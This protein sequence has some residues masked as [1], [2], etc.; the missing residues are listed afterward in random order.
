M[1][2]LGRVWMLI[3]ALAGAAV[4]LLATGAASAP[5]LASPHA[6]WVMLAVGFLLTEA[7][8]VHL[9]FRQSRHSFSLADVPLVF[10]LLFA[11]GWQLV[12]GALLGTVLVHG[13]RRLPPVKMAFNLAQLALAL[14]VAIRV[15]HAFGDGAV[16]P[17]DWASAYV[18]ALAASGVTI[19]S[20]IAVISMTEGWI[21][22]AA[23]A[24]MY[25]TDLTVTGTNSTIAIVASIVV[26]KDARALPLLIVLVAIGFL[27]YRGYITERERHERLWFLYEANQTVERS[28][29]VAD[30]VRALLERALA[31]FRC[32]AAELWLLGT[33]RPVF[34]RLRADGEQQL[35]QDADPDTARTL[36]QSVVAGVTTLGEALV[37]PLP[38]DDGPLG[39]LVLSE[40]R[41]VTPQFTPDERELARS[42]AADAA[43]A[44]SFDRLESTV[45]QLRDLEAQLE[46]DRLT[47]VAN[48]TRF[49]AALQETPEA[50]VLAVDVDGF[51]ALNDR[52][53]HAAGDRVLIAVAQR[54]RACVPDDALLARVGADEFGVLASVADAEALAAR[55]VG[56]F[57]LPL[58][59]GGDRHRLGVSVGV[60]TSGLADADVA[61]QQAKAA[62]GGRAEVFA[63]E[64]AV[65]LQRR[66]ALAED[67]RVALR[68]G[69]LHLHYQ[70]IVDL[71]SGDVLGAEAL[72]RWEHPEHGAV[73]PG[74]FVPIAEEAGL[75]GELGR[76]VLARACR[77]LRIWQARH[78]RGPQRI[79]VNLS[80]H[81]LSNPD[82]VGAVRR[83][84]A[85]AG[86]A[87]AQ[88]V[89]EVTETALLVDPHAASE[90]FQQLRDAG[91]RIALDD[92]GT[93]YSSLSYLHALPVDILK[94]AK[95]FVDRLGAGGPESTFAR[96]IIELAR[97]LGLE[98][99]AEGIETDAQLAALRELGCDTG[100]GF[101]LGR[102][103]PLQ[104]ATATRAA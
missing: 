33:D 11:S 60:A 58:V 50:A 36:A 87:P 64:M 62:G 55:L 24:R 88:L 37:A 91:V 3:A 12:A 4:A 20:L 61:M 97:T 27:L 5:A 78:G 72:A 43:V 69:T 73:S 59:I 51:K 44:L 93:G 92:F 80:A 102:P 77:Q 47:Q 2:Q 54:L 90:R 40:R 28:P 86:V 29:E 100:Q 21:G 26:A 30:A 18:A 104:A 38:G 103:G 16:G 13:Y 67:L 79:Q 81:E 84:L 14:A 32:G 42:L 82:L 85:D 83:C 49:M 63:P 57:E 48:R 52:L 6:D 19:A 8:V 7:C 46:R 75:A 96:T 53:G 76:F 71:A 10:G 25:A 74:E 22:A 65:A 31:A 15:M 9:A 68:D 101:L 34:T 35:M 17:R 23:A 99:V 1:K 41:G 98:V 94:I 45:A 39:V 89:L 70:P 95:P 56:A 66:R